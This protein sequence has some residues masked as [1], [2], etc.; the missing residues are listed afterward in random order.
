M[1]KEIIERSTGVNEND[2]SGDFAG[3]ADV[4]EIVK[5]RGK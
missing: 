3:F 1:T 2:V 4:T 5:K